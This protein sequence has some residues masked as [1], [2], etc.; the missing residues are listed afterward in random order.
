MTIRSRVPFFVIAIAIG[1]SD[2]RGPVEKVA[3]ISPDR[4]AND[5]ISQYDKD[6]DE[7][8]DA[9]ELKACPALAVAQ[10]DANGDRKVA[11]DELQAKFA[12]IFAAGAPMA[13]VFCTVTN[14]RRPL[15]GVIVTFE[16]ESFMGEGFRAA[17]GQT[18]GDGRAAIGIAD[19]ELLEGQRG[20]P[21]CQVGIYRVKL[22]GGGIPGTLPDTGFIVDVTSRGGR[23]VNIDISKL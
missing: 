3:S 13:N 8:L 21:L 5:A 1:C 20:A 16:P 17:S 22:S 19:E 4:I 14:G 12:Q 15:P 18:D 23:E 6:G 7:A 2:G 9:D 11:A 10:F